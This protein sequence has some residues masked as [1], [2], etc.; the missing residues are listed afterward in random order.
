MTPEGGGSDGGQ[1]VLSRELG[2]IPPLEPNARART[3]PSAGNHI[4]ARTNFYE[5]SNCQRSFQ[6]SFRS[7]CSDTHC[8]LSAIATLPGARRTL[9]SFS[10]NPFVKWEK[11]AFLT[12]KFRP[13]H[14]TCFFVL[15]MNSKSC[16]F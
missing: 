14:L 9:V 5:I 7:V 11:L 15:S 4:M 6:F 12:V 13:D 2:R 1:W 16:G 8:N 10:S 3:V